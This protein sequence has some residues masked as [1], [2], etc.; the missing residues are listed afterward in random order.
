LQYGKI[1]AV[2]GAG[3]VWAGRH[4]AGQRS[5][6]FDALIIPSGKRTTK[7]AQSDRVIHLVRGQHDRT[8]A[9]DVL[10][11]N[12]DPQRLAGQGLIRVARHEPG[13]QGRR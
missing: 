10:P 5:T 9:R 1:Y 8:P 2:G 13:P 6:M 4:F 12:Q 11:L 3:L 7:L